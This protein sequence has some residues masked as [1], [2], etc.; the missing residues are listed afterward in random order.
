MESELIFDA[1]ALKRSDQDSRFRGELKGLCVG[2]I[3]D[4]NL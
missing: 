2:F 1:R 3:V 4:F